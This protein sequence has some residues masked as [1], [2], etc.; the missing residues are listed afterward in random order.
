[1]ASAFAA[2]PPSKPARL[3]TAVSREPEW[4]VW[5]ERVLVRDTSR[6]VPRLVADQ[7]MEPFMV[8]PVPPIKERM[9]YFLVA[10]LHQ[11][12][13]LK[14]LSRLIGYSEKY[15]SEWFVAQM[16]QSFSSYIKKLRVELAA[17][18]LHSDGRLAA[19]AER[20][21][22][23]D[24]YA[25]SHF[26]KKATGLSPQAFRQGSVRSRFRCSPAA[27]SQRTG[28]RGTCPTPQAARQ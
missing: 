4:T 14:D 16:G 23:Q 26:F 18:L 6:S 19:I 17:R 5:I 3:N 21:G 11:G 20:L 8:G 9:H 28:M 7:P 13:T 22:F 24:Q 10:N 27:R 2:Q 1:M 25:F 12:L 15:C